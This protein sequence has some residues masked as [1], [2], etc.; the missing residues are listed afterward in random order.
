MG[1]AAE[2]VSLRAGMTTCGWLAEGG[3]GEGWQQRARWAA[4]SPHNA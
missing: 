1:D 4:E 2:A 3:G